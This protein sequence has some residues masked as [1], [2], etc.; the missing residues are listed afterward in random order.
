MRGARSPLDVSVAVFQMIRQAKSSRCRRLSCFWLPRAHIKAS[1]IDL[2]NPI[3]RLR[4]QSQRELAA[5]MRVAM[6]SSVLNQL[7]GA[8]DRSRPQ[9][10]PD[11]GSLQP[12][13]PKRRKPGA[14]KEVVMKR[15]S[16]CLNPDRPEPDTD[17]ESTYRCSHGDDFPA[18]IQIYLYRAKT[19]ADL[20]RLPSY[21]LPR[22]AGPPDAASELLGSE[23][24]ENVRRRLER[25]SERFW[26][27][28]FQH[29]APD[30][31]EEIE[32]RCLTLPYAKHE[33]PDNFF[34]AG[35]SLSQNHIQNLRRE[36]L[37]HWSQD[38]FASW[39]LDFAPERD[40]VVIDGHLLQVP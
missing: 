8:A 14:P 6:R 22:P 26:K 37:F 38:P 20:L 5:P 30:L 34:G 7:G 18:L 19:D 16:A 17:W 35:S 4:L 12:P 10:E 24:T 32:S 3:R 25:T 15:P 33:L 27:A 21:D 2:I 31:L 1:V 28:L 40:S 39:R 36:L 9:N 11:L 29:N 13:G 23:W